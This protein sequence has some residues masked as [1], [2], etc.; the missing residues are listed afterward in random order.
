MHGLKGRV[1]QNFVLD[2]V[3]MGKKDDDFPARKASSRRRGGGPGWR[4]SRVAPS[5]R[6]AKRLVILVLMA[7]VAYILFKN[8]P[9]NEWRDARRPRY[10]E[11]AGS[12]GGGGVAGR[13]PPPGWAQPPP[14]HKGEWDS[15]RRGGGGGDDGA[16]GP[17][18]DYSPGRGNALKL[19]PGS[20]VDAHEGPIEFPGLFNTLYTISKTRDALEKNILFAA[21]S[22]KSASNI[23]P[24]AC[25]MGR[26]R[27]NFVHFALMS[28]SDISIE[29]LQ[30]VNG[31]NEKCH[32]LFHGM[33]APILPL[34][35]RVSLRK[36]IFAKLV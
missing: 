8:M 31:I 35:L 22:L 1:M 26:E 4:P 14:R 18:A 36:E 34:V 11:T 20:R 28:H 12:S 24:L 3:E 13:W 27:R 16:S 25:Q 17:A 7:F 23:L 21:S 6:L 30:R 29:E 9:R 15:V 5:R 33:C 10:E 2:D 19:P 32:I